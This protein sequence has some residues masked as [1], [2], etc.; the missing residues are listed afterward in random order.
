MSQFVTK[1]KAKTSGVIKGVRMVEVVRA[2]YGGRFEVQVAC[3]PEVPDGTPEEGYYPGWFKQYVIPELMLAPKHMS[4]YYSNN[5]MT[6]YVIIRESG[7]TGFL[8]YGFYRRIFV[9]SEGFEIEKSTSNHSERSVAYRYMWTGGVDKSCNYNS[10][11]DF[12]KADRAWWFSKRDLPHIQYFLHAEAYNRYATEWNT[13][14]SLYGFTDKEIGFSK[15]SIYLF[16]YLLIR[17]YSLMIKTTKRLEREVLYLRMRMV[18]TRMMEMKTSEKRV[19]KPRQLK[20]T[21]GFRFIDVC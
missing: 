6:E 19:L 2:N 1:L 18:K 11:H 16:I 9:N 21:K 17:V 10:L 5:S 20:M 13:W 7:Q 8:K 12:V 14:Q 15:V 3:L 4:D